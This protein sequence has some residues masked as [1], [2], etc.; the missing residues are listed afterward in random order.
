MILTAGE[1]IDLD[2]ILGDVQKDLAATIRASG[3]KITV[4]PLGRVK[5]NAKQLRQVF[6]NLLDNAL[7]FRDP[8]RQ[9]DIHVS[10][11]AEAERPEDAPAGSVTVL[12]SDN[13]IGIAEEHLEAVFEAFR[14]LHPSDTRPGMG[15]GLSFCRKIVEGLGGHIGVRSTPGEGSTFHLTLP[16]A[17]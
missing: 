12:V 6:W 3:A 7:K 15:L 17:E 9:P 16:A 5:G 13:G 1:S 8:A 14:R 2:A 4:A 10:L 11:A